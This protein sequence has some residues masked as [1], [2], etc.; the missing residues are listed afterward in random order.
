VGEVEV[1]WYP[2]LR[3]LLMTYGAA[4]CGGMWMRTASTPWGPWSV[5]QRW[6][7]NFG[8]WH[9][10][11]VHPPNSSNRISNNVPQMYQS[12]GATPSD[13][14]SSVGNVYGALLTGQH[15]DNGDGTV[16]VYTLLSAFRPYQV[17]MTKFKVYKPA[18]VSVR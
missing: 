10:K 6:F 13:L 5:E 11:L 15:T 8:G 2:P 16:S 12:D 14:S 4:E 18:S 7:A 3:R 17:W 1:K 9:N